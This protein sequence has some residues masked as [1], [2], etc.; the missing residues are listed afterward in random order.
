MAF[1]WPSLAAFLS[2]SFSP[3]LWLGQW[4]HFQL[5]LPLVFFLRSNGGSIGYW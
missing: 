2:A 1:G 5:A 3:I 4:E